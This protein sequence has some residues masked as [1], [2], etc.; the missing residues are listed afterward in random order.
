MAGINRLAKNPFSE[1]LGAEP[2]VAL[3]LA[4]QTNVGAGWL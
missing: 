3:L 4:L 1:G 2:A